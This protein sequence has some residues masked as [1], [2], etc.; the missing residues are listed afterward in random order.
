[1]KLHCMRHGQSEYNVLGLCNDDPAR[2]VRLTKLGRRQAQWAAE[3]LAQL[4]V[5]QV[6]CSELPRARE[7]AE[8][9]CALL[10]APLETHPGLNDIRSGCD[11]RPVQDYYRAIAHD[12]MHARVGSGET[13]A[14]HKKRVRRFIKWLKKRNYNDVLIV[15]HEE[16]LRVF[17]AYARGLSDARMLELTF[18][19]CEVFSFDL[20]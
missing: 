13:L 4:P 19:N 2:E 7:T 16:T 11:G 15:A 17:A 3:Q 9:V 6:F 5:Q 1:M 12:R 20:I 10:G 14:E 8:I 18:A